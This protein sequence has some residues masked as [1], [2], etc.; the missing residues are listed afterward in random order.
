MPQLSGIMSCVD[1][2]QKHE[3]PIIADGGIRY[4]GDLAKAIAAGQNQLCWE[5]FLLG[6]MKVQENLSFMKVVNINLIEEWAH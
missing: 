2:A 5:V 6:W 1:E 3:I 4:S